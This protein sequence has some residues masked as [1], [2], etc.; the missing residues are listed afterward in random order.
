MGKKNFNTLLG[1]CVTKP[2]GK[3]TLAPES[4]PRPA[5]SQAEADFKDQL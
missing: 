2:Q 5:Y 4:D 1:A 3:P